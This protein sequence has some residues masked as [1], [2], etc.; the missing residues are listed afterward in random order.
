MEWIIRRQPV[1]TRLN[2]HPCCT[3][4]ADSV[5]IS[6]WFPSVSPS[7][8]TEMF[9]PPTQTPHTQICPSL[10][11]PIIFSTLGYQWTYSLLCLNCSYI[12][13]QGIL[14]FSCKF[15]SFG[16]LNSILFS[17][18]F[19]FGLSFHAHLYLQHKEE[20]LLSQLSLLQ[21]TKRPL[22]FWGRSFLKFYFSFF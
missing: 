2:A 5:I 9:F 3:Q 1:L 7:T 18:C 17:C 22:K 6:K 20:D 15:Q 13:A 12:P 16:L 8:L 10:S 4:I 14:F 11:D 19:P 21:K